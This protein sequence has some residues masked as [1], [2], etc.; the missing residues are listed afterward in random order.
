M[1]LINKAFTSVDRSDFLPD[2]YRDKADQDRPFPIG[3]GQT[4]SQPTTVRLML[5][6]LDVQLSHKVLDLGSGSGW[7]TALLSHIVG[8]D[9]KIYAVENIPELVKQGEENFK[10]TNTF[11][12]A[13]FHEAGE[14]LGLPKHAPY[15]RILVSASGH[16][17]PNIL[18]DQLKSPGK[19]VIPVR[20]RIYVV[21]KNGEG[22]IS[23][24]SHIGFI[25]V[26]LT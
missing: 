16:N 19:M 15:D 18:L 6:W 12:N 24:E 1:D 21:T 8:K 3:Y 9:G 11:N 20:D 13:E 26:P 22:Q 23:K 4:N 5:E 2:R 17:V 10:K 7:T 25:F 14:I